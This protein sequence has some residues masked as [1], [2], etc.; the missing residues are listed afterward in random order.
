MTD[1]LRRLPLGVRI[2]ALTSGT[3]V[4]LLI[5]VGLLVHRQFR[6]VL[7]DEID[8]SLIE[9]ARA[10]ADVDPGVATPDLPTDVLE[11][12][13]ELEASQSS[14]D[15]LQVISANGSVLAA[16]EAIGDESLVT[17]GAL[18]RVASGVPVHGDA[19]I[20][21]AIYRFAGVQVTDP[22]GHIVVAAAPIQQ[23]SDTERA[24]LDTYVPLTI[25]AAAIAALAGVAI[26]RSSL[27]PLRAF[28]SEADAIGSLDLSQRLSTPPTADEIGRL[29]ATLNRMLD[30][31]DAA[32]RRE[33]QLTAE[34][35]HELRTPLAIIR[36][37]TELLLARVADAAVKL[38]LESVLEEIDRTTGVID[39]MLLL[40]RADAE[41]ALD[42]PE[43]VDLGGLARTVAARFSVLAA[44]RDLSLEASGEGSVEGDP[45]G[46][47]RAITNLVEN[48]LRH[49]PAGGT[50]HL[51]VEQRDRG[52]LLVVVDS[53]PGVPPDALASLFDR[54]ARGG[55]QRGAAGLGLSIVAAVAASHHG[56]VHAR[57]RPEGGLEIA[58][59]LLGVTGGHQRQRQ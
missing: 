10:A 20:D 23:V 30:R 45:R 55:P 9:R 24:L 46:M 51:R 33:R 22:S 32:L 7:R 36:A 53:G 11:R 39:D 44:R 15:E 4:A 56:S 42:R 18:V 17:G 31:L 3:L 35:G 50:V 43:L 58:V 37:E 14:S 1:W 34:V 49:T 59:E 16:T 48:A 54:Y 57:N 41:A 28:A 29:G 21:G 19:T 2:A 25:L 12:F 8:R 26:A 13:E 5:L 27:A 52:A 6:A 47:E 38:S 40:A